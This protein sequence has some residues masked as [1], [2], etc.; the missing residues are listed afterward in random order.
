[1][2]AACDR[3]GSRRCRPRR[4][5]GSRS[6]GAQVLPGGRCASAPGTSGADHRGRRMPGLLLHRGDEKAGRRGEGGQARRPS[7]AEGTATGIL[8][9]EGSCRTS[10]SSRSSGPVRTA[11]AVLPVE[12][13]ATGAAG[14]PV[15]AG[16]TLL[17]LRSRTATRRRL[18][19]SRATASSPSSCGSS[20]RPS[21]SRWPRRSPRAGLSRRATRCIGGVPVAPAAAGTRPPTAPGHR[22]R[23][24]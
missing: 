19:S 3:P 20:C 9:Q 2:V 17:P 12:P 15:A 16:A 11:T 6:F 21:S 8:G 24:R 13:A 23:Q 4:T 5:T 22:A 7:P 14:L 1:M 18:C 10:A